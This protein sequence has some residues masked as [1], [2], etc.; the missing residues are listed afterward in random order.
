MTRLLL[1][2]LALI[3]I[4]AV[5]AAQNCVLRPDITD[6]LT[7][8]FGEHQR[9]VGLATQNGNPIIIELWVAEETGSFTILI[10]HPSGMSCMV[11]AGENYSDVAAPLL[12]DPM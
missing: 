2:V 8:M 6:R 10:T 1:S 11:A 12:G 7:D 9:G 3:F 5:V 4:P